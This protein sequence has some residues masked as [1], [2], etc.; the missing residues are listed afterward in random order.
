MPSVGPIRPPVTIHEASAS[1]GR[2]AVLGS[3]P[4]RAR[5]QLKAFHTNPRRGPPALQP[6]TL[7]PPLAGQWLAVPTHPSRRL[8]MCTVASASPQPLSLI[9]PSWFGEASARLPSYSRFIYMK[10]QS[11]L[12][13][14][15]VLPRAVPLPSYLI[16]LPRSVMPGPSNSVSVPLSPRVVP[17]PSKGPSAT[18]SPQ[19]STFRG[20]LPQSAT[21]H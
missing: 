20:T 3:F 21:L 7:P 4:E 12:M 11:H 15:T 14:S 16:P 18:P 8:P 1:L 6:H 17:S 13:Q 5:R 2:V 9:S 10:T 19:C